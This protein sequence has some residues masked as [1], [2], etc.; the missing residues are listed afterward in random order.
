MDKYKTLILSYL[1][2]KFLGLCS[3]TLQIRNNKIQFIFTKI[4]IPIIVL[5][6]YIIL[7]HIY[8]IYTQTTSVL[9]NNEYSNIEKITMTIPFIAMFFSLFL[10]FSIFHLNRKRFNKLFNKIIN[11][12]LMFRQ[13]NIEIDFNDIYQHYKRILI[14]LLL[15]GTYPFVVEQI[16]LEKSYFIMVNKAF[17]FLSSAV[18]FCF[19]RFLLHNMEY[20]FIE[21]AKLIKRNYD[22]QKINELLFYKNII[23]AVNIYGKLCECSTKINKIFNFVTLMV[24]SSLFLSQLITSYVIILY[25]VQD[26]SIDKKKIIAYC[27]MQL[28]RFILLLFEMW[29]FTSTQNKVC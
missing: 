9:E 12:D 8:N 6:I 25:I 21:I 27:V 15:N 4:D 19:K 1:F 24:L 2:C 10:K 18:L 5:Q 16:Y 28:H 11:I 3:Y 14:I 17:I 29:S 7:F 23:T 26:N 22:N 20:R 13:I